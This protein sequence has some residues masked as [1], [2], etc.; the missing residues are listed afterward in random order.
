MAKIASRGPRT[1]LRNG[2]MGSRSIN[3]ALAFLTASAGD[4]LNA[5]AAA[6][7]NAVAA[8][9]TTALAGNNNDL[10]LTAKTKGVA[11]NSI[12]ITYV[13]P[14]VE[15][16]TESVVVTG[17]DIVVTLRSVSSVLST[18]AQVKAAIEANVAANALVSVANA[19]GNDGTGAVIALAKTNLTGGV[20]GT[21]AAAGTY[22]YHGGYAYFSP[23]KST[24]STAV[25]VRSGSQFATY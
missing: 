16:A 5:V 6:P 21:P 2:R 23:T 12:S 24:I 1:P 15:T 10:V 7:V 8:A 14:G 17:K 13:N 11:G 19:G 25:W 3:A 4:G 9:C 20:D 18:A 22:V